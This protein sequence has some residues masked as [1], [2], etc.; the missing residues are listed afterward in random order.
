MLNLRDQTIITGQEGTGY[1]LKRARDVVLNLVELGTVLRRPA[2][3][4]LETSSKRRI[5]SLWQDQEEEQNSWSD[6]YLSWVPLLGRSNQEA[7]RSSRD[8]VR[9][10]RH[11]EVKVMRRSRSRLG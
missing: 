5:T 3:C 10:H 1:S 7:S 8:A 6:H 9:E 2:P 4:P 11:H